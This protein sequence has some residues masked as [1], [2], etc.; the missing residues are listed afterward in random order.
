M[1][2]FVNPF[3]ADGCVGTAT[4]AAAADVSQVSGRHSRL[5]PASEE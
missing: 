2:D 4:R 5:R 1:L 3:S